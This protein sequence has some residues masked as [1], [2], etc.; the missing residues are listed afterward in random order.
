MPFMT[1]S[2]SLLSWLTI[3]NALGGA[4]APAPDADAGEEEEVGRGEAGAAVVLSQCL[5]VAAAEVAEVRPHLA[6][7][8]NR[9]QSGSARWARAVLVLCR[10]CDGTARAKQ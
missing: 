1:L 8:L 10:P 6:S 3:L 5:D 9:A 7:R 4:G 2:R